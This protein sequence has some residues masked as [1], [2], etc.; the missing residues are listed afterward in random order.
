MKNNI[1]QKIHIALAFDEKFWPPAY[2]TMRSVCLASH[3]RKDLVFHLCYPGL[4]EEGIKWLE[5][6]SKEFGSQIVHHNIKDNEDY[7]YFAKRLPYTKHISSVAYARMI[8][9]KIIDKKIKRLVYLDCDLLIRAPIEN[10]AAID[11]EGYPLGAIKDAHQLR[12][13]NGRDVAHDYDLLDP[14]DPYFNSGVLLINLEKWRQKNMVKTL[15][16]LEENKSL[17]R[18][19][20]DQQILNYIFAN[21]WKQLDGRWNMLAGSRAIEAL[22]PYIVHYTGPNKPWNLVSFLPFARVYRHV[23]TNELFYKYM[24]MRWKWKFFGNKI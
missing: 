16:E 2:A 19:T 13:T 4:S 15:L 8:L 20:H 1:A 22:D 21:N 14:A 7:Q 17:E 5:K 11:L 9:D 12:W 24:R 23:M 18:L 10:F 6:I 3:K